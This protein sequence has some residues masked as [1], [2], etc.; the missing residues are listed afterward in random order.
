MP[1][2][3]THSVDIV[4]DS[5]AVVKDNA[6]INLLTAI[7]SIQGVPPTTLNPLEQ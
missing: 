5:V 3:L 6:L 1:A 4:A 2:S 7:E